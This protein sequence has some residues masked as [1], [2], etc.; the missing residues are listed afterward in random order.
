MFQK[1]MNKKLG[2]NGNQKLELELP[3]KNVKN[4]RNPST[5]SPFQA[6]LLRQRATCP[7]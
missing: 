7:W 2:K 6:G 4:P 3:K 1:T 5:T